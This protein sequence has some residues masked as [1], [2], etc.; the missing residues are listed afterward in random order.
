MPI[1]KEADYVI[2][3][4]S[5]LKSGEHVVSKNGALRGAIDTYE[6]VCKEAH[7]LGKILLNDKETRTLTVKLPNKKR[8]I[9]RS[10][11]IDIGWVDKYSHRA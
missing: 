1:I 2:D 4:L 6:S 7:T 3:V 9:F 11:H 8:V 10:D 5:R